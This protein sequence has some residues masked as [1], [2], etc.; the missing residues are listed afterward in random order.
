MRPTNTSNQNLEVPRSIK[1][2]DSIV[3]VVIFCY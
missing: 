3:V 1:L 2:N